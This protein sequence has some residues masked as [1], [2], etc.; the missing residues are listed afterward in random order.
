MALELLA[1]VLVAEVR[2]NHQPVDRIAVAARI[3]AVAVDRTRHW[4][5]D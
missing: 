5:E 2:I 3:R 1:E 4:A